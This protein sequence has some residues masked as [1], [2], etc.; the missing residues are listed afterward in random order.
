MPTAPIPPTKPTP[1][2]APTMAPASSG[3]ASSSTHPA[4]S[5][6]AAS[7][8]SHPANANQEGKVQANKPSPAAEK[9]SSTPAAPTAP[10]ALSQ[11][12]ETGAGT[13]AGT[14]VPA[15]QYYGPGK[16]APSGLGYFPLLAVV[17]VVAAVVAG[18]RLWKHKSG[19][20]RT[21]LDYSQ[22]TAV[23]HNE[24]GI[25]IIPAGRTKAPKVKEHFE[26]RI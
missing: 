5:A 18:L 4:S 20:S 21:V 12:P 1:P 14:A 25:D 19:Q 9:P 16:N 3:A 17:I 26:I 2:T 11:A 8:Q 10:A 23:T 22:G 15:A 24:N 13:S 6:P 7:G